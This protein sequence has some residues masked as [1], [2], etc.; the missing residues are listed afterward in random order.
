MVFWL[1]DPLDTEDVEAAERLKLQL[2]GSM[3]TRAQQWTRL[4]Q[5][6]RED[7]FDLFIIGGGATGT[8]CAVD[9][10]TRYCLSCPP[11]P[12]PPP[13]THTHTH[14]HTALLL[15][16]PVHSAG[17]GRGLCSRHVEQVD[18][19]GARRRALP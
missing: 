11:P 1:A 14:T 7:P 18:Q 4:C 8:G 19:A 3:P 10:V 13:H 2:A 17:G 12:P 5:G 6:T 15:Q 16:G 9:A